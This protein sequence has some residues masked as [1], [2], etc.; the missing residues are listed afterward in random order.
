MFD[1][2]LTLKQGPGQPVLHHANRFIRSDFIS[3]AAE[4][5][6]VYTVFEDKFF[7]VYSPITYAKKPLDPKNRHALLEADQVAFDLAVKI[8][9]T[10]RSISSP[11]PAQSNDGY[12]KQKLAVVSPILDAFNIGFDSVVDDSILS[13]HALKSAV[14]EA[15]DEIVSRLQFPATK[16]LRLPNKER[17]NFVH[18]REVFKK[19]KDA[20]DAHFAECYPHW[21]TFLYGSFLSPNRNGTGPTSI[22]FHVVVPALNPDEYASHIRLAQELAKSD[23]LPIR[24][25][26]VPKE[27]ADSFA[28]SDTTC[29]L[30]PEYSLCTDFGFFLP[31]IRPEQTNELRIAGI[32]HK[33]VVL[34]ES[35]ADIEAVS[36]LDKLNFRLKL[37][38]RILENLRKTFGPVDLEVG[39]GNYISI[40][41]DGGF[42]QNA[43]VK[44]NLDAQEIMLAYRES[45]EG[46][47]GK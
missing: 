44:A 29:M 28:V 17:M 11:V 3:M 40:P 22:D 1:P 24:F 18:S 7:S 26:L 23:P 13:I 9:N 15:M 35:L 5:R 42:A 20:L 12:V 14:F 33:L 38:Y 47:L 19:A 32:A 39:V 45:I 43:L 46:L 37:P 31:E 27:H 30:A 21:W 36:H 41:R 4:K 25:T 2:N 16:K 6:P 8:D 34:R 10:A